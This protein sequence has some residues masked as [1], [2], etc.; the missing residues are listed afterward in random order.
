MLNINRGWRNLQSISKVVCLLLK[1]SWRAINWTMEKFKISVQQTVKSGFSLS[2]NGDREKAART[3]AEFLSWRSCL[4]VTSA[5]CRCGHARIRTTFHLTAGL[6]QSSFLFP[7]PM[8]T[9][10]EISIANGST[11]SLHMVSSSAVK[12][13]AG[14]ISEA[15]TAAVAPSGGHNFLLKRIQCHRHVFIVF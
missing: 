2:Q 6:C 10:A 13:I 5:H 7:L 15:T 11:S 3:W 9:N 4:L 12:N 8:Y 14:N 1:S